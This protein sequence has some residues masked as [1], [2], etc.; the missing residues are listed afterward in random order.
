MCGVMYMC[1]STRRD[2]PLI[3]LSGY[4]M[5]VQDSMKL[6][7]TLPTNYV[8]PKQRFNLQMVLFVPML[9]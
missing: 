7:L 9:R 6:G 8:L 5:L 1:D 2:V 4:Y 3:R